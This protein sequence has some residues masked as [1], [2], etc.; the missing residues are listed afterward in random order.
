MAAFTCPNCGA[1]VAYDPGKDRITCEYCGTVITARDYEA[2]LEADGLYTARRLTCTRCGAE[3]LT[4]DATAATFCSYCGAPT[5]IPGSFTEEK[6]PD[7]IVPFKITAEAAK[8]IYRRKVRDRFFT[9]DWLK[10]EDGIEKARG[11]YMPYYSYEFSYEADYRGEG[12]KA[13]TAGNYDYIET[14]SINS[15][16]GAEFGNMIADTSKAF[17]DT[18]SSSILP[19]STVRNGKAFN[20]AYLGG[21]YADNGDVN[22][23]IYGKV[24]KSLSEN[25]ASQDRELSGIRVSGSRLAAGLRLEKETGRSYLL[26]VWF[27]HFKKDDKISYAAINGETGTV[28]ADVPIDFGKYIAAS[29]MAAAVLSL[30]FNTVITLKPAAMLGL[31]MVMLLAAAITAGSKLNALYRSRHKL[32]DRG[33]AGG[34]VSTAKLKKRGL[35]SGLK[36]GIRAVV[37]VFVMIGIFLAEAALDIGTFDGLE[38]F[39]ALVVS[40]AVGRLALGDSD[41]V[42]L[43]AGRVPPGF[44]LRVTWKLYAAMLIGAFLLIENSVVDMRYYIGCGIAFA[45]VIWTYMEIVRAH[46]RLTM[47]DIPVFTEKRGGDHYE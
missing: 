2:H 19:F 14:Y 33:A 23:E 11:I 27:L 46:N 47:R 40:G 44:R 5:L 7:V 34:E 15:P 6:R 41:T 18:L 29:L 9:P 25:Y 22:P 38:I 12:K 20:P 28:A 4:T 31:C 42:K 30:L 45:A 36:F 10:A 26:P 17:P 43:S 13:Y 16:V 8:D 32:N 37:F 39:A 1:P 35:G 21:F 3:M 24:Y